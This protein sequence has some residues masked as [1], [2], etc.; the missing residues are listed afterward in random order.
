MSVLTLSVPENLPAGDYTIIVTGTSG[1][2]VKSDEITEHYLTTRVY[3]DIDNREQLLTTEETMAISGAINAHNGLDLT[4]VA[5]SIYHR[6]VQSEVA[7]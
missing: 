1:S 7:G 4:L 3:T 6:A 5:H 2:T